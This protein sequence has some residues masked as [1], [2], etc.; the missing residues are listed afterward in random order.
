M[1]SVATGPVHVRPFAALWSD[2]MN[3]WSIF[4]FFFFSFNFLE[5]TYF[6]Y[7]SGWTVSSCIAFIVFETY[8]QH[9]NLSTTQLHIFVFKVHGRLGSWLW[10][11]NGLTVSNFSPARDSHHLWGLPSASWLLRYFDP[12]IS[13]IRFELSCLV[14]NSGSLSERYLQVLKGQV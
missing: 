8:Q 6:D 1:L 9:W 12:L 13:K 10:W 4:L 14:R 3:W 5:N 2:T 11:E 7:R